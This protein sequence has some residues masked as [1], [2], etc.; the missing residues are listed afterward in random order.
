MISINLDPTRLE[1]ASVTFMIRSRKGCVGLAEQCLTRLLP[2]QTTKPS[3]RSTLLET[4][5]LISYASATSGEWHEGATYA[6]AV[7][8]T[9]GGPYTSVTSPREIPPGRES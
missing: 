7:F 4:C 9:P 1:E 5:I 3:E 6:N 2:T 8:P